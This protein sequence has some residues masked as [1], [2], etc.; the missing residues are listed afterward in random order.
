MTQPHYLRPRPFEL[1]VQRFVSFLIRRGVN[2]WGARVLS[3][4]GRKSGEPRTTAVN[5]LTVSGTQYLVA[6]RGNTE[7]VRNLRVAGEGELRVGRRTDRF[8]AEE[9]TDADKPEI[10]R[11]YLKRWAF[12]VGQFFDGV[13]ADSSDEVLR[14]AAPRHPVFR[15]TIAR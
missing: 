5:L 8:T 6:A 4:R 11:A 9:L 13:N 15:V 3:V 12:E 10:L 7:W 1:A 2:V 14:G